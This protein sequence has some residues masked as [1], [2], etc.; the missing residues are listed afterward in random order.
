[1][2]KL[3]LGR[4]QLSTWQLSTCPPCGGIPITRQTHKDLK[5]AIWASWAIS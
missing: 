4:T 5:L 2:V 1:M 3:Y